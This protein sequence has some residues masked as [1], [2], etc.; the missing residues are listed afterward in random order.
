MAVDEAILSAHL[1]GLVPPTL[2]VYT[3]LP[4]AL[5]LGYSQDIE[6]DIDIKQ[7]SKVG[8][9]IVRRPTGGRA[10]LHDKELTY[11][12]VASDKY[13][14]PKSVVA[15]YEFLSRGLIRAYQILGLEVSIGTDAVLSSA[16]CFLKAAPLDLTY[17]GRKL[18]GSAQ[19][20]RDAAFL[21][22]GS[23]PIN[24]DTDILFSLFKF[25]SD[26]VLKETKNVF[27]HRAISLGDILNGIDLSTLKEALVKGFEEALHIRFYESS[28]T[29][30][31]V[32]Q[33]ERLVWEKYDTFAWNYR[34][35]KK[36]CL[37]AKGNPK[38]E[39]PIRG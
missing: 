24:L 14:F 4:P 19:L 12:I 29:D 33:S 5:S 31:E 17:K 25:P 34:T 2:R 3:W 16:S 36:A 32:R 6:N 1:K 13:G 39:T 8:I 26:E 7:C 37:A 10:V 23:L 21:Q 22:H 20:R 38:G 35:Q 9:D 18:A 15:C 11:S 28:L 30:E 27:H